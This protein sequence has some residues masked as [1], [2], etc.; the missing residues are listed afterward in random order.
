[1]QYR[2]YFHVSPG[3]QDPAL[4]YKIALMK[5]ELHCAGLI[6]VKDR[7]LLLA[8]SNNKRA[9]YLPGGKVDAGET[10]VNGLQREVAEELN[11]HIPLDELQWYHHIS[12]PAFGENALQMQQD[13]FIHTLTQTPVPSSE[14]G[15]VKYFSLADYRKEPQQVPGVLIAFE[16]LR[17]DGLVD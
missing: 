2:Q 4:S 15:A 6:V 16:K 1:L 14:I 9:W 5:K 12:A 3:L 13:C 8:F 17:E 7:Q 10:A 11:I